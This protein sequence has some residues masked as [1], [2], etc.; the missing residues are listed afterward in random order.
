MVGMYALRAATAHQWHHHTYRRVRHRP[1]V[2][3]GHLVPGIDHGLSVI[4]AIGAVAIRIMHN[5]GV[6]IAIPRN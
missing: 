6:I 4:A 5:I 3:Q 1:Q 2:A